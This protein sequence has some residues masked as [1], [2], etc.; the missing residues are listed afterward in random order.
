MPRA[1]S[2][3]GQAALVRQL[4][5]LRQ[6]WPWASVLVDSAFTAA[7]GQASFGAGFR[8]AEAGGCG[9]RHSGGD[10]H[11]NGDQFDRAGRDDNHLSP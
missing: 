2:F 5:Q 4:G 10:V 1:R 3:E 9:S 8:S 7:H 11:A 6:H